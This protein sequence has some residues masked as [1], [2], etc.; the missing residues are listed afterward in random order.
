MKYLLYCLITPPPDPRMTYT[1]L[2][3]SFRRYRS[4]LAR[5]R[6]DTCGAAGIISV[7]SSWYECWTL[8]QIKYCIGDPFL[9]VRVKASQPH[10]CPC[11]NHRPKV[12][13]NHTVRRQKDSTTW[14]QVLEM[15]NLLVHWQIGMLPVE[16]IVPQLWV[17]LKKRQN[18]T[19]CFPSLWKNLCLRNLGRFG[20]KLTNPL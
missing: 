6:P 20:V 14:I 3:R 11:Q 4:S 12:E 2:C 19:S 18:V 7:K 5:P 10:I 8:E 9:G 15:L 1:R 17:F 16:S 13:R